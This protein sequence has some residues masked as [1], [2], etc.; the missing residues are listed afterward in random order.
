MQP[1]CYRPSLERVSSRGA[2][3]HHA[4]RRFFRHRR[5]AL[6]A[7]VSLV[8]LTLLAVALPPATADAQAGRRELT[9]IGGPT[10][11]AA[12]DL[13]SDVRGLGLQ[14]AVHYGL[15]DWWS[16]GLT[17]AWAR[18]FTLPRADGA[19]TS[20]NVGSLYA[21]PALVIDVV[22]IVPFVALGGGVHV[23]GGAIRP[24]GGVTPTI[25]GE[26][27]FDVRYERG[28]T[29]GLAV[30]WHGVFPDFGDYPGYTVFWFRVGRVIELDRLR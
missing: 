13:R 30:D 10:F 7:P 20:A 21:G 4:V 27:G 17:A 23:D 2:A 8:L 3:Q 15:S 18:H 24:Q 16:L 1:P 5:S 12:P 22:R 28:W 6:A 9:V 19:A 11:V 14:A 29:W 25:R 26:L